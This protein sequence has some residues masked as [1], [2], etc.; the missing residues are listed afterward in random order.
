MP[1]IK[2]FG[3]TEL[4]SEADSSAIFFRIASRAAD[5]CFLIFS[6]S[7]A[8]RCWMCSSNVFARVEF[9]YGRPGGKHALFLAVR[10]VNLAYFCRCLKRVNQP[11]KRLA[12]SRPN[13]HA[14]PPPGSVHSKHQTYS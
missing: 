2:S 8:T 9:V 1:G 7:S 5:S 13:K 3:D 4:E 12:S 6:S 11:G 14:A 10:R